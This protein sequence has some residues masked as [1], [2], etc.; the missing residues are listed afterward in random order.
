MKENEN[1]NVEINDEY[2]DVDVI[3]DIIF[4]GKDEI[5]LSDLEYMCRTN[6]LVNGNC[7]F[8]PMN[9]GKHCFYSLMKKSFGGVLNLKQEILLWLTENPPT[10]FL[11]DVKVKMQG[12]PLDTNYHIPNICVQNLYGDKSPICSCSGGPSTFSSSK[13]ECRECWRKPIDKTL[14]DNKENI[15][16]EEVIDIEV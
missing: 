1:I 4:D 15:N 11:M 2:A 7:S 8:C 10:S 6:R 16:K 9:N 5:N 12:I 14:Q 3:T 13:K